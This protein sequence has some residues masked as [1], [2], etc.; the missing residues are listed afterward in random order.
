MAVSTSVPFII[1]LSWVYGEKLGIMNWEIGRFPSGHGGMAFQAISGDVRCHMTGINSGII[2]F[3]MAGETFWWNI[4]IVR[5]CVAAIA[6]RNSMSLRKW[7]EGMNISRSTPGKCSHRMAIN[8]FS[9]EI[10][11]NMIW[12][13]RTLVIQHVTINTFHTKRF[14]SEQRC[15][16]M[17]L[18][19]RSH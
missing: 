16:W 15:R 2:I 18:Q 3:L 17:A 13:R 19:T 10:T 1:V 12:I 8:A 5:S 14:K 6:V 11:W 7:E 4:G 9:R